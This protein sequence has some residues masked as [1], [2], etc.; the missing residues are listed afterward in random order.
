MKFSTKSQE[1]LE[2]YATAM[3]DAQ[4]LVREYG[5][6]AADMFGSLHD[7]ATKAGDK[8]EEKKEREWDEA[9]RAKGRKP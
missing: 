2:G 3:I 1:F 8:I 4:S 6:A 5:E 9:Q 7:A